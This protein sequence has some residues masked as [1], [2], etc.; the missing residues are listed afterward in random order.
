MLT[1][2]ANSLEELDAVFEIPTS[3]FIRYNVKEALPYWFSRYVFCN[4]RAT[5]RPL[6][7]Q[8]G[9]EFGHGH[10]GYQRNDGIKA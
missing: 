3:Q 6:L 1:Y 9:D 8:D 2:F 7:A 4:K 5:L 10:T